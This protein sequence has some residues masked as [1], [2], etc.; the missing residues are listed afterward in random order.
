M[1]APE[2]TQ[3]Q[4]LATARSSE[5]EL[6]CAGFVFFAALFL[7]AWTLAPTVTLVDSGE[8]IVA[9]RSL[10]VA[11]PPGFPLWVMLA[12]LV[13]LVPFGSVA[14]RINFSSALF[15]AL[16]AAVLTLVVA[17][18]MIIASYAK[19][20]ER[21]QA[22]KSAR[23]GTNAGPDPRGGAIG[24]D[25]RSRFLL[26]LAPAVAAGLLMAFSRTLWGYAT[27][28][29]VYAL[30]TLIILIIFFL[31]LRWRRSIIADGRRAAANAARH[32]PPITDYDWLLYAAAFTF[33]LALGVHHVTVAL[34]LPALAVIVCR[35]EGWRFFKSK[36]LIYAAIISF[37]GLFAV[38]AFLPLAASRAPVINWGNPRSLEAIWWHITG[39]QYQSYFSFAPNMMAAEFVTFARMAL[40]EFGPSWLPLGLVLAAA[41]FSSAFKRDRTS[42]WFLFFVVGANLAYGLGYSIAEDK[43]AYCLP[44]FAALAI[45]AGLG[46]RWLIQFILSKGVQPGRGYLVAALLLVV[47]PLTAL[48][49]NWPF[50]NRRHYFIAQDYVTNILGSMEP[51]GLLLTFDWQVASPMLYAQEVEKHRLDVKVVDVHLLRRSWYFDYLRRAWPGLIERSRDRVD[52]FVTELKHWENDP[53]AYANDK[54]LTQRI[55]SRFE[56]MI[57]SFVLQENNVAPVYLTHDFLT[58]Q[59]RDRQV[60]EWLTKNYQ[61][62]PQG[63]V[64]K[65]A[66]AR[67][68]EEQPEVRLE[69]RGLNDETLKFEKDDVV[70]IKVLPAY[71][72]MLVNQGRYHASLNRHERAM[73]AFKQALALDP[74]LEMARQGIAESASKLRNP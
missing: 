17:E 11:H 72:A 7:Y 5:T 46:V 20:T 24:E 57:Q 29:E 58:P 15:G 26:V 68:S 42:F 33:G 16:A 66:V 61:L 6:L 3:A 70:R 9:A 39:R 74:S 73:S 31:M 47:V 32:A 13:S 59:D 23:R 14:V 28:T 12:H 21:R 60:S 10:G 37:A 36:R 22:K 52:S 65:L 43:D 1:P 27:V 54:M 4:R 69:T 45:A 40:R 44:A 38:Y 56:E 71:T 30:N 67:T 35:T 50:N 34:T 2:A 63:I 8:L 48:A 18:L 41:G 64:F 62:I 25:G 19:I 55:V 53:D 51:N 49:G